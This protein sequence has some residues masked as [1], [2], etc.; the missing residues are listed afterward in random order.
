MHTLKLGSWKQKVQVESNK[1]CNI[2]ARTNEMPKPQGRIILTTEIS[3][4]LYID[5]ESIANLNSG[6][7]YTLP[8]ISSGYHTF[9]LNDWVQTI[10][11]KANKTN[12]II[13]KTSK[14]NIKK[15]IDIN[16]GIK[17]IKIEGG[18]FM[19]GSTDG[20]II[21]RPKHWVIIDNFSLS[22]HEITIEQFKKFIDATGYKT[23]AEKKGYSWIYSSNGRK[24]ATFVHW[25]CDAEGMIRRPKDYSH[26]VTYVS[27]NDAD[28]YCKWAGG[29][30]P[31]EAEWEYAAG[32]M[33]DFSYSGSNVIDDVAWYTGNSDHKIHP[34]GLL[35]PNTFSLFDMSGNVWEWCNDWY[36]SN[37]YGKSLEENPQG[38][39]TGSQRIIRGGS[40][41]DIQKSCR[42]T[43]RNSNK[44]D[45]SFNRLGFRLLK[46]N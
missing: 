11:V 46:T 39:L 20:K 31:T 17:M 40:Y 33:S 6:M 25:K 38:A 18:R 43:S 9:K 37:Y 41:S 26:P 7:E 14:K 28:V 16:T 23:E 45:F 3:G 42:V 27:W 29:R 24:K 21:E 5:D 32:A 2:T 8:N 36:Q 34:V 35:E 4:T 22:Q 10:N 44:P 30:L 12:R 19:M 15:E 13:A 1:T